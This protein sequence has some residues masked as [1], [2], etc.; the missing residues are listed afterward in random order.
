MNLNKI[1]YLEF[2]TTNLASTKGFFAA[3][4]GWSFV[5]YG[6]EYAAFTGQG[7]DGGFYVAASVATSADGAPLTVFYTDDL[8][9]M[10]AKV[11][12][13]GGRIVKPIFE[14]PGGKRFQFIEPGGNELAVWS[15]A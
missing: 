15:E 1:D 4:F 3:A 5:D 14:F 6:P 7:V 8:A 12:A 2:A 11:E 10:L 9:A 13:A